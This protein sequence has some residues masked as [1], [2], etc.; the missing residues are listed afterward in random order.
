MRGAEEEERVRRGNAGERHL[1]LSIEV[2]WMEG[3]KQHSYILLK[4]E[5]K[6]DSQCLLNILL[7]RACD[8]IMT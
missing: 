2:R 1:F 6:W 4:S 5:I 7:R 8:E 3:D